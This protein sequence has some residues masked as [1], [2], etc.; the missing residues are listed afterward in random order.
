MRLFSAVS[1]SERVRRLFTKLKHSC[2]TLNLFPS[3]PPTTDNYELR[4]QR[5]ST[6]LFIFLLILS[7]SVLIVYTSVITITETVHVNTPSLS[8]YSQLYSEFSQTL[9]CPCSKISVSNEKFLHINYTLHQV[10]NST[11]VSENWISY[12]VFLSM[13]QIFSNTDFR[14]TSPLAFQTLS[15]F[16]QLVNETIATS[17]IRFYSNQYVSATVTPLQLFKTQTQSLI[18][19][20]ISSTAN[21]FTSSLRMI[22]D[23]TQSNGLFSI[24][25][26]NYFNYGY[27]S[28]DVIYIVQYPYAY[29]DCSCVLT[30]TCLAQSIIHDSY[31][32]SVNFVVPGFYTGC[33]VIE[34]LR[35]ST[36]E[37][38]YSQTCLDVLQPNIS[39]SYSMNATALDSSLP[40]RYHTNSTVEEL[41]NQL[42]VEQWFNASMFDSYYAECEPTQ[43]TYTHESKNSA[44]YIVTTIVGLVGGLVTVLKFIVPWLVKLLRRRNVERRLAAGMKQ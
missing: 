20:F 26:T 36:L 44:V 32:Y 1:T 30:D 31:F 14:T 34:S 25:Q 22:R 6:R 35:R 19:E 17:L 23:T 9:T 11:F 29:G 13:N 2:L 21:S 33:Y 27:L 40:S 24:L 15:A 4:N 43:C 42:M 10:C 5:I 16:C 37:C 28:S 38:F 3:I 7:L 39:V 12:L 18:D 41:L 8:H